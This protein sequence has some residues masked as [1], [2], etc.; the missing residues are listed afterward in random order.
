MWEEVLGIL[1][2]VG[3]CV[4]FLGISYV[5]KKICKTTVNN[6]KKEKKN[7]KEL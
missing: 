4:V 2:A 6:L 5:V 3:L 1:I 7:E